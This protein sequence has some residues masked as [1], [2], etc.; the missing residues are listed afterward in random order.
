MRVL[1]YIAL[2][3]AGLGSVVGFLPVAKHRRSAT[4]CNPCTK[5]VPNH[6][7][8]AKMVVDEDCH[9][10]VPS[11]LSK[12]WKSFASVTSFH[13]GLL[14]SVAVAAA[15]DE[16]EMIELPPPYVPV[17]VAIGI[18]VGV[19]LLTASLGDV[20]SEG[21]LPQSALGFFEYLILSCFRTLQRRHSVCSP[22]REQRKRVN[23]AVRRIL[24]KRISYDS[25][26]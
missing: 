19:G 8:P 11:V 25:C 22:A 2:I 12:P 26:N 4:S 1:R 6:L 10:E 21:T 14:V 5:M 18:L 20:M 7:S 16:V 15:D 3:I 24:R 17:I 13:I 23:E 9:S